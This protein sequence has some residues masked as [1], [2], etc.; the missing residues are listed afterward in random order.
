MRAAHC[1]FIDTDNGLVMHLVPRSNDDALYGQ[2]PA[3]IS[4]SQRWAM[5]IGRVPDLPDDSY[6]FRLFM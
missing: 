2:A 1:L 6:Q 3:T 4:D 5:M